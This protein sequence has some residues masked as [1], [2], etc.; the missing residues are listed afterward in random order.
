MVIAGLSGG[1]PHASAPAT[2][3]DAIG[4]VT[5]IVGADGLENLVSSELAGTLG[6]CASVREWTDGLRA[7]PEVVGVSE[8]SYDDSLI[9]A[10]GVCQLVGAKAS[11][12]LVCI[13]VR[14]LGFS[15]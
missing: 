6:D 13:E 14:D 10:A 7:H 8:L 2:C 5:P 15:W 12:E 3:E 11:T 4:N 9:Y 1:S